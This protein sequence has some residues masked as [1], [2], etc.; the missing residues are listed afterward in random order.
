MNP[1][2]EFLLRERAWLQ[3]LVTTL[4][5]DEG[6]AA[7]L[8]QD[9]SLAVLVSPPGHDASPRGWLAT[10]ARH[11]AGRR[12]RSVHR[13]AEREAH[14]ARSESE[15]AT[16]DVVARAEAYRGVVDA[17][18]ALDEPYRSAVLLRFFEDQK[19]AAIAAQLGCPVATV[20][21]RPR[22]SAWRRLRSVRERSG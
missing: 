5:R 4:V 14:A 6:E 9:V 16:G 3:S 8:A 19:P 12:A 2:A 10:V 11:L 17:V 18:L 1:G 22:R 21:T 20:R 13:R 7:D 15:P